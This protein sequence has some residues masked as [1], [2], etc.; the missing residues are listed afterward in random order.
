[1]REPL[2]R[3]HAITR[4]HWQ[5]WSNVTETNKGPHLQF[6][7]CKWNALNEFSKSELF[8]CSYNPQC[9]SDLNQHHLDTMLEE[10]QNMKRV[11]VGL[12]ASQIKDF[13]NEVLP[14]G[15]YLFRPCQMSITGHFYGN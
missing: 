6:R 13:G 11:I 2:H 9:I 10:L 1:M 14:D 5:P 7:I 15:H 8:I 3:R 12:S 4:T